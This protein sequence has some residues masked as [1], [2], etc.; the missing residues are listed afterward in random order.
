MTSDPTI[1]IVDDDETVRDSLSAL[2]D[3]AGYATE[4]FGSAQAFLDGHGSD[5]VGCLLLDVQ[6]P[7]M[8]GLELQEKLREQGSDL[9]VIIV[10]G[11]GDVQ[12]AV[13]AMRSGAADFVEKPYSETAILDSVQLALQ[14]QV[15]EHEAH[16]TAQ[17]F[18]ELA[19]NLTPREREVLDHVVQG[20]PNKII[21]YELDISPRTVEIHRAR[22]MEKMQA[23]SLSHLV[24]MAITAEIIHPP[25]G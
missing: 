10:T 14:T 18:I 11:F 25:Q 22:V 6:M 3:S 21:A 8:G 13:R 16:Q 5:D 7:D 12:T 1:W 9:P 24:R 17:Q 23:K 19:G 15:E 4:T 20:A 2:L